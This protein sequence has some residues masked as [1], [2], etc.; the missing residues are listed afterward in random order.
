MKN[1]LKVSV[2]NINHSKL[3]VASTVLNATGSGLIMAFMMIYFNRT[4]T[5]SLSVI[6]LAIAVGRALASLVPIL[7]GQLLDKLG[8]KKLSIYGD[9]ISGIGFIMC[10]FAR[11]PLT[12]ILT[13]F[14]TQ[15]GSHV[16]WTSN[17]GLVALASDCK[18]TQT[19]FGLI[20]SIR[21]IG[22]GLGTIFTSLALS[23]NSDTSLHYVIISS[24]LFYFLS[25]L[26]LGIWQP[27]VSFDET[28]DLNDQE[29]QSLKSV[30]S[31]TSYCR[32]LIVNFG[33]VLAA[34]VIPLVIVIYATEQ[35]GLSPFFSGGLVIL[36][37]IIVALLSTH[38]ASWTKGHDPV[39][40]IKLSYFLNT[41]SF[42]LF[43]CASIT[44]E[45]KI[46]TC[47]ILLIAMLI[48]S[49]AEMLSTPSVNVLSINLAPRKKNGSY[50]AAF[51]MTWSIGMTVSPAIFGWLLDMNKNSTWAV[52]LIL[53]ILIFGIGF[54]NLKGEV[55][56]HF[57]Y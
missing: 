26:A 41:L 22:L 5:L 54:R 48:Y 2:P 47:F 7:I 31:D 4:T 1:I 35:L 15:A 39:H 21:N 57:N 55:N 14:L 19:W 17:R 29:K 44:I 53:T 3:F 43:W 38:V 50:M 6:G 46:A 23:I 28:N 40:N 25:C 16:F 36:N 24:S 52:L 33:L 32:L 11:D 13:Q 34:M 56:E 30:F 18:G 42:I 51:Q 20:A 49:F 12:I 8:P 45:N 27:R 37:T 10:L 9:F